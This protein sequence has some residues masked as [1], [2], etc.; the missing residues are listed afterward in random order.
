MAKQETAEQKLLKMIE[1]SSDDKK[2]VLKVK[3]KTAKKHNFLSG[4]KLIN[5][6]LILVVLV[7]GILLANEILAGTELLNMEA[8]FSVKMPTTKIIRKT[9]HLVPT[10]QRLSY[11]LADVNKRNLFQPYESPKVNT[12]EVTGENSRIAKRISGLRLVGVSWLDTVESASIMIEDTSNQTT[13][14]LKRGEMFEDITVK[15]IYADSAL[16]GFENEE[17]TIH[18]DKSQM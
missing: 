16:L 15:T 10:T 17:I 14:F 8:D 11:Y 9:D 18:Y 6:L 2:G 13:H 4:V 5:R 3:Q 7:C 12:A 1:T